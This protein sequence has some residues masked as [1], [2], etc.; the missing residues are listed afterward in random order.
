MAK[1]RKI[2]LLA[3][4]Y[5]RDGGHDRAF[6]IWRDRAGTVRRRTRPGRYDSPESRTALEQLKAEVK[7]SATGTPPRRPALT[8]AGLLQL[9]EKHAEQHYRDPDGKPTSEIHMV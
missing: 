3:P 5:R 4:S 9:Y 1:R 6:A 7:A 2:R 8:V